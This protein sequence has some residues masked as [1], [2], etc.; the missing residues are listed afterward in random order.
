M[1]EYRQK[2]DHVIHKSDI[3]AINNVYDK[4]FLTSGQI[5]F[6]LADGSVLLHQTSFYSEQEKKFNE[7]AKLIESLVQQLQ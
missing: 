2:V 6:E 3:L 7:Y 5:Q 1:L 4:K